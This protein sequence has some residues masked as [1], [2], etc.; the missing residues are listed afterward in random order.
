MCSGDCTVTTSFRSSS[1]LPRDVPSTLPVSC[2][3]F[4]CSAE[5]IFPNYSTQRAPYEMHR[6][7]AG[8]PLQLPGTHAALSS[9]RAPARSGGHDLQGVGGQ[10]QCLQIVGMYRR[11]KVTQIMC[12]LCIFG[13][14][15][16]RGFKVSL[17]SNAV[18]RVWYSTAANAWD[19]LVSSMRVCVRGSSLPKHPLARRWRRRGRRI[20]GG[21]RKCP[22]FYTATKMSVRND[23]SAKLAC[24]LDRPTGTSSW[25]G[26]SCTSSRGR[27]LRRRCMWWTSGAPWQ[28]SRWMLPKR[29]QLTTETGCS[30]LRWLGYYAVGVSW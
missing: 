25:R 5:A 18:F 6:P 27:A 17:I 15:K 7:D 16:G 13:S 21:G 8:A 2:A 11:F 3:S 1:T 20:K 4:I 10:V 23:E 14:V 24:N 30:L 29:S 9:G 28:G 12:R 19:P 26:T 22:S